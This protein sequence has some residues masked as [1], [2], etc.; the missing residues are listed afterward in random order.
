MMRKFFYVIMSCALLW[1]CKKEQYNP[2]EQAVH[3]LSADA[4][5]PLAEDGAPMVLGEQLDNPYTVTNM[6]AALSILNASGVIRPIP[7]L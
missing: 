3:K 7:F 1:S 2:N 4:T 5:L 6:Q